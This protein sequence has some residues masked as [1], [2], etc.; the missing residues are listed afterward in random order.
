MIVICSV[1]TL[2][3]VVIVDVKDRTISKAISELAL[4]ELG[5]A[6]LCADVGVTLTPRPDHASYIEHW[7]RVMKADNK[8]TFAAASKAS[9]AVGYLADLQTS[10]TEAAT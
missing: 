4:R 9:Q 8:A 2:Q 5:A 6:F 7:L 10:T 3:H 1:P